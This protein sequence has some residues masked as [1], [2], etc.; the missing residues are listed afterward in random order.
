MNWR[1]VITLFNKE[2]MRFLRVTI[3]T[4]LTPVVTVLLYL[5]IFS[6]VLEERIEVYNHHIYRIYI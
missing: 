5:L 1:G 2:V 3:Q 4:I 6:S